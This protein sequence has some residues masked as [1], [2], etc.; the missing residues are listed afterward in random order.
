LNCE[1]SAADRANHGVHRVPDGIHPW[2]L[3][4]KKFEKI[5]D[6]CDANDPGIA[7]DFEGLILRRQRDPLE[8]DGQP[9]SKDS[10]VKINTRQRSETERDGDKIHSFHEEQLYVQVKRLKELQRCKGSRFNV[11][12]L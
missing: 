1:Q 8:M 5:E 11:G 9:S 3:V 4:G 2:N 7:Q 6:T 12:T 10:Q